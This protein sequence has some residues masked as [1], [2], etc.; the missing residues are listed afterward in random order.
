MRTVLKVRKFFKSN[1]KTFLVIVLIPTILG[2]IY[3]SYFSFKTRGP[4]SC[5]A[6]QK[7]LTELYEK[8]RNGTAQQNDP[9]AVEISNYSDSNENPNCLFVSSLYSLSIFKLDDAEK[10][11][12][13]LNK[14]D[15]ADIS[16]QY[17]KDVYQSPENFL[18]KRIKAARQIQ[19]EY[20]KNF[21]GIGEV[22]ESK[23]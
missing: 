14:Q 22:K 9:L 13:N 17:L 10:S 4:Y 3:F 19:K 12:E 11:L 23:R 15:T 16:D 5:R 21:I 18:S 7:T 6:N 8:T 2:L 20:Q 1:R